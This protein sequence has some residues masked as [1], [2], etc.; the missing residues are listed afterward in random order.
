MDDAASNIRQTI[1]ALSPT[2]SGFYTGI[3]DCEK[4]RAR[5]LSRRINA[6]LN[7]SRAILQA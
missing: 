4:R 2:I 5:R 3:D 7:A 1:A 6:N